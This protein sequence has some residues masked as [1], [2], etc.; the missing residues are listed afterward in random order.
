M[1]TGTTCNMVSQFFY[2]KKQVKIKLD[3]FSC[4]NNGL[5]CCFTKHI[6]IILLKSKIIQ[7]LTVVLFKA[8]RS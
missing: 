3:G 4:E 8:L 7:M 2:Y 6:I 1:K 5:V